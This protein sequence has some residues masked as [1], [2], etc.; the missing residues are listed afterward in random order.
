MVRMLWHMCMCLHC[1][2]ALRG[3]WACAAPGDGGHAP[4]KTDP[5]GGRCNRGALAC[6][7]PHINLRGGDGPKATSGDRMSIMTHQPAEFSA[8]APL[9]T[10]TRGN[11]CFSTLPLLDG[12]ATPLGKGAATILCS[13]GLVNF[14]AWFAA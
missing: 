1:M 11:R 2:H 4:L 3:A 8:Q 14:A 7:A 12:S 6:S 5:G 9:A 13:R 10:H